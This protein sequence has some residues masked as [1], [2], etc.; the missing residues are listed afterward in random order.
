MDLSP[1]ETTALLAAIGAIV[2]AGV[3]GIWVWG[4]EKKAV[5]LER[6]WWR[7]AYFQQHGLT[8]H[9]IGTA[10]KAVTISETPKSDA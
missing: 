9:A 1:E 6:D 8:D 2:A 4:R 3:K 5:E 7:H 10:E